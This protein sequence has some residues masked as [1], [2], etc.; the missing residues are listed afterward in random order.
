MSTP[1]ASRGE[2]EK[3]TCRLSVK[4]VVKMRYLEKYTSDSGRNLAKDWIKLA[5]Q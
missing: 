1:G 2:N 4:T 5:S 3:S